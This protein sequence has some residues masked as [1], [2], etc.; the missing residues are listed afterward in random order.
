VIARIWRGLC[1]RPTGIGTPVYYPEDDRYLIE[2]D[3]VATH[4][5]V[6]ALP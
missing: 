2:R 1:G 5:Q 3:L 6:E 4:Y